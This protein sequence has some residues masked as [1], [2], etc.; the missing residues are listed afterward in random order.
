MTSTLAKYLDIDNVPKKY[1]GNLDW[2]FGDMPNLEPGIVNSM[3]WKQHFEQNGHKTLPIGPIKWQYD[4]DGELIATAIGTADGK[5]RNQVI[6]GLRPEPHVARLALSAGRIQVSKDTK[7]STPA[8]VQLPTPQSKPSTPVIPESKPFIPLV[9]ESK[10]A[11]DADL[12]VGKSPNAT[13]MGA[14]IMGTY[15]VPYKDDDDDDTRAGTSTTRYYQQEGT[16]A[17]GQL[18]EGTPAVKTDSHSSQQAIMDPNTVG[19]AP[20]EHPL[21]IPEEPQPSYMDQA[22]DYAGHAVDQAKGFSTTVMNAVGMGSKKEE[23]V[24]EQEAKKEPDHRFDNMSNKDVEEYL[25]SKTMSKPD[26]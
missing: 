8:I 26:S 23:E 13:V 4:E 6:A 24:P 20:K 11:S 12:N 7:N 21:P 9:P 2:K 10:M 18:A 17:E 14:S 22:K 25:R 19:Q 16:H 3:T 15:T 1:G 5:P